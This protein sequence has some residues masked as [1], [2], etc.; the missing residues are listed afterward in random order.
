MEPANQ[1][2]NI[3]VAI[4]STMGFEKIELTGVRDALV[5][6]GAT[7]HIIAPEGEAIRA[8]EFPDWADELPVDQTLATASANNYDALYIPGGIIN[9]DLL[10]LDE[11]AIDFVRAFVDADK[12]IGSMC[13]GPWLLVSADAVRGRRIASWPS[14]KDD[15]TNAGATWADEAAVVDGNI[16]TAR[17]PDD[18]PEFNSTLIAHFAS[19][20]V[21]MNS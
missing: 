10:R 20:S 14:L 15:L 2:A 4:L 18:I 21:S 7:V 12:P 17:N 5:E 8:F 19:A 1:L 16:V 3:R 13:H 11:R 6:A 9:P